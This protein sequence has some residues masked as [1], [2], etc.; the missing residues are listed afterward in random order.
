ML[1]IEHFFILAAIVFLCFSIPFYYN[2]ELI[3]KTRSEN[4]IAENN[5]LSSTATALDTVAVNTT[6]GELLFETSE[7]R[8]KAI[9]AFFD[10]YNS[11]F[12]YNSEASRESAKYHIPAMFLVDW[13]GYYI[14]YMQKYKNAG[15]TY[16]TQQVTEKNTW[17][18][19]YG[20]YIVNY[21]LDDQ[22]TVYFGGRTYTGTYKEVY[23]KLGN[24]NVASS[25]NT[26][27]KNGRP[28]NM[29][30][31]SDSTKFQ[32]ERTTVITEQLNEQV[33]YYVN[34]KNVFYNTY[35]ANYIITLP[36]SKDAGNASILDKPSLIAFSQ[37]SEKLTVNGYT[38]IYTYT[39]SDL[40]SAERYY[41]Q[42]DSN[43]VK[44]Y[45]EKDCPELTK[46]SS[47]GTMNEC[48]KEGAQPHDC[49]YN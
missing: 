22:V 7:S 36:T 37:G 30:F 43:G 41:I 14:A 19:V 45:H 25:D 23:K 26:S 33:V 31:M 39:A 48:A 3:S 8:N 6:M 9:Q 49:V 12:N 18:E 34:T 24:P 40:L 11:G 20:D 21:R 35:D 13:D 17:T 38:S 27:F 29:K 44:Y 1:K 10:V 5:T 4:Q 28:Q 16:Y 42:A 47:S 15:Q 46:S 2:S 32:Q